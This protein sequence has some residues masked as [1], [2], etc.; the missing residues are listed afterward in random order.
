MTKLPQI[1]PFGHYVTEDFTPE[2]KIEI[3]RERELLKAKNLP[4]YDLFQMS[5]VHSLKWKETGPGIS[6]TFYQEE[7]EQDIP[8]V[9]SLDLHGEIEKILIHRKAG[10]SVGNKIYAIKYCREQTGWTLYDA[11]T[12]V[13]KIMD[14]L[15]K[16]G[17]LVPEPPVRK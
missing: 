15:T 14:D 3:E 12:Y 2:E 7:A 1:K 5:H 11:K 6:H 4:K 8:T 10:S 9:N 13:E 17:L 16:R